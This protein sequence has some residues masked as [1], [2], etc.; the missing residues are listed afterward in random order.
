MEILR[1]RGE[2]III[3]V[4]NTSIAMHVLQGEI[5]LF[6]RGYIS[7]PLEIFTLSNGENKNREDL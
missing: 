6:I 3:R 7:L 4:I 5:V 2:K 1:F